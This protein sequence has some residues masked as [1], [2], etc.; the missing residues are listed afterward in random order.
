MAKTLD[1]IKADVIELIARCPGITES[2]IGKHLSLS[3]KFGRKL[4]DDMLSKGDIEL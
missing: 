3:K 4:F 2:E 1:E